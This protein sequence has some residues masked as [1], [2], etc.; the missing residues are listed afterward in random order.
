MPDIISV[1][2][3][4]DFTG[5]SP[6]TRL[7]IDRQDNIEFVRFWLDMIVVYTYREDNLDE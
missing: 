5:D 2:Y 7:R 4:I 3:K 6:E 1:R